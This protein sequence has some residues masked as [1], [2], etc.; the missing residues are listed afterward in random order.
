M[1]K[2]K[3]RPSIVSH[4]GGGSEMEV[5]DFLCVCWGGGGGKAKKSSQANAPHNRMALQNYENHFSAHL[6]KKTYYHNN[7]HNDHIV[8]MASTEK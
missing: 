5:L 7:E 4:H 8:S 2:G 6:S 3:E 1:E